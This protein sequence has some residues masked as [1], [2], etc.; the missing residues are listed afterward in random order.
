MDN[1]YAAELERAARLTQRL[2]KGLRWLETEGPTEGRLRSIEG[3]VHRLA[4]EFSAALD[5]DNWRTH[6][7]ELQKLGCLIGTV[8]ML[9]KHLDGL[10]QDLHLRVHV[11]DALENLDEQF[12]TNLP[13]G[14]T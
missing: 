6:G 5:K 1:D 10:A 13:G 4:K 14:E 8:Q 9:R 11:L 12:K 2:V 7:T 3:D